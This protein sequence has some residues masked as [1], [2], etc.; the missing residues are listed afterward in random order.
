MIPGLPI[1]VSANACER[2]QFRFPR[3][4][5]RRVRAK[6]SKRERNFKY[7][8]KAFWVGNQIICHPSIYAQL[9]REFPSI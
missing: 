1:I 5:K 9:R 7:I 6:W 4:K 8:P 3:T 2:K